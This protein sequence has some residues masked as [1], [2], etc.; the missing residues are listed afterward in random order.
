M[1]GELILRNHHLVRAGRLHL[2]AM[3]E[4]PGKSSVS[5]VICTTSQYLNIRGRER[6][7]DPW[8]HGVLSSRARAKSS[9]FILLPYLLIKSSPL[10]FMHCLGRTLTRYRLTEPTA[11]AY[12]GNTASVLNALVP[13]V[14]AVSKLGSQKRHTPLR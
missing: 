13:S 6:C 1:G 10:F 7:W 11:S 14:S 8:M 4:P 2:L 5:S 9:L 12:T 3:L